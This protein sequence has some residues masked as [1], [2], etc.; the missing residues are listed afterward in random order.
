MSGRVA[1]VALPALL[2]AVL[3]LAPFIGKPFT[4][5]DPLFLLQAR[6]AVE[7]P[8]HPSAFEMV[9]DDA[10]DGGVPR[11]AASISGPVMAWLLVPVVLAD[12]A[13]WVGHLLQLGFIA[14]ALFATAGLAL[15][16]GIPP[17]WAM[18]AC[19][20]TVTAPAVLGMAGT[21][22]PDVPAMALGVAGVERLMAW[23]QGRHIHQALAASLLLG[24]AVLTRTHLALVIFV[25]GLLVAGDLFEVGT[26]RNVRR[27]PWAPLALALSVAITVMIVTRDPDPRAGAVL[28]VPAQLRAPDRIAQN[29]VSFA[30][31][32]ALS[33]PLAIPW[34]I[35]RF[36]CVLRRWWLLLGA[37]VAA[38]AALYAGRS[39]PWPVAIVA[40]V[41]FAVLVDIFADG[42]RR[43]DSVQLALGAWLLVPLAPA[44]YVHLPPKYLL[45]A[46]PA[47]GLLVA[48]AMAR[49]GSRM[50]LSVFSLSAVA[51][52]ALGVAILR[53]D[54]RF[55]EM[56]R[57]AAKRMIA[58]VAQ[59]GRSVW[60]V[61]SWG[62]HWYAVQAGARPVTAS[63][64]YPAVGDVVVVSQNSAPSAVALEVLSHFGRAELLARL[65]DR[66]PGGRV[67]SQQAGAGFYSNNVGYLPWGWGDDVLDRFDMWLLEA[68]TAAR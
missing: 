7:D 61:G 4:I 37:S 65:E 14:M 33:F 1:L 63:P 10:F 54:A 55:G 46:A 35:L 22:M 48:R 16:V 56:G 60:F 68:P 67:M 32:W 49:S 51:G 41:T 31:H 39:D 18:A 11:R 17:A 21:V 36:E 59:A 5:D 25:A 40:A 66:R 64:P 43:R 53:A 62:F 58:P 26:W 30:V 29:A 8:L 13:E 34:L 23:K 50:A 42:W 57:E 27:W 20:L 2:L 47:A 9:W 24:L 6:H 12:G 28:G 19:V 15:R 3:V 52:V 44:T 45:A 38:G